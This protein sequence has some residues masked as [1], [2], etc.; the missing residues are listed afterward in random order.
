MGIGAVGI[1]GF[2]AM[3][4]GIAQVCLE[5]GHVVVAWDV[6]DGALARGRSRVEDG[7]ARRVAKDQITSDARDRC[8]DALRVTSELSDLAA[9]DLVIEAI[10]EELE[11]KQA[12][13][14][15]LDAICPAA[16]IFATNT[17]ALSVSAIAGAS[18]RPGRVVG[19]HFFNPAPLMR[20]VEVVRT[21]AVDPAVFDDALAFAGA[22]GKE[23]VPCADTPGFLVNRILI[24]VLN[25]A[26]RVLEETGASPDE[27]DRA[28]RFGAGWPMGPFA[29][30][31]MI[32][33]D[34]QAHAS[35]A[36]H[37][38]LH[39]PRMAA[40]SRLQRLVELGRLG[41]KS[42]RGFHEHP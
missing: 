23:A 28:M 20:L 40:P 34:V 5:A 11:P 24:P 31:D 33:L 26:I 18:G 29:L 13:F 3:G 16:T 38:G 10:V 7:L 21:L 30:M 14:A 12:L 39:E 2:G 32:G 6:D 4:S 9:V 41:R 35:A 42:G 8:L 1:A 36:L 37:A 15:R 17:S 22:L 25:D 19:L 27:I